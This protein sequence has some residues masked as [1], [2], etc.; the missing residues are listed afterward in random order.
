MEKMCQKLRGRN[1]VHSKSASKSYART[2]FHISAEAVTWFGANDLCRREFDSPLFDPTSDPVEISMAEDYVEHI[3]GQVEHGCQMAIAGFIDHTY[4]FGSLGFW[5]MAL[6]R[7]AK[8]DPF[9]S[10]GCAPTP[11][12]LAQSK[13]RKGSN[14]AIWQP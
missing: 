8:F 2:S 12:T 7:A 6:L 9:V 3:R 13:E 14:F 1:F 10:L 4:V 11:S 5:T